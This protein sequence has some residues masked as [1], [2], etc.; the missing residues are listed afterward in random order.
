MAARP[1]LPALRR[2]GRPDH[3]A[4][5]QEHAA[6]RLQVQGMPQAVHRDGRTV[7]ERSHI[8]LS[9]WVL[10]AHFMASSKKGMSALQLQRMIGTNYETA[11]FLFHVSARPRT[12]RWPGRS[13]AKTR[14]WKRTKPISAARKATST[15]QAAHAGAASGK[16]GRVLAGRARRQVRSRHVANV[17]AKAL[18]MPS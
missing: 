1:G 12:I 3:Q 18:A 16:D 2:H 5:R 11:W 9:K 8:P 15:S 13:A 4:P 10:A 14:S 6:G 7:M 17:T